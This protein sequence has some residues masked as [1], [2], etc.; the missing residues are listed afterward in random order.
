MKNGP[1]GAIAELLDNA[2][3][4]EAGSVYVDLHENQ[5]LKKNVLTF[6]DDGFGTPPDTLRRMPSETGW[7]S[8]GGNDGN[9]IGKYG[10]GFK[11][12]SVSTRSS[13]PGAHQAEKK[14]HR[15]EHGRRRCCGDSSGG[16][17]GGGGGGGSRVCRRRSNGATPSLLRLALLL[18]VLVS[19]LCPA[20]RAIRLLGKCS[21]RA[22]N[23]TNPVVAHTLQYDPKNGLS[24]AAPQAQESWK[25]IT[26]RSPITN[27][28]QLSSQFARIGDHGT[29]IL[30]SRL[31]LF[32]DKAELA[33]TAE[34]KGIQSVYNDIQLM[35]R[36]KE[37]VER[38]AWA[39]E[40][41]RMDWSMRAYVA[42]LYRK[43]RVHMYV[44][45]KIVPTFN[46]EASMRRVKGANAYLDRRSQYKLYL[47]YSEQCAQDKLKG[48]MM[49]NANRLIASDE[50]NDALAMGY[51][52]IMDTSAVPDIEVLNNKQRYVSSSQAYHHLSAWIRLTCSEFEEYRVALMGRTG[53]RDSEV[54]PIHLLPSLAHLSRVGARC[55]GTQRCAQSARGLALRAKLL[56]SLE[57]ALHSPRGHVGGSR[58]CDGH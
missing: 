20:T 24:L 31:R 51:L 34:V 2:S 28:Q 15:S 5:D 38:R 45:D 50:F 48:I 22:P 39:S 41:I 26:E 47:G 36:R 17:G 58:R 52:G 57:S 3:G 19:W 16:D 4:A 18:G 46:I 23:G 56:G 6:R 44:Q 53:G 35:M 40:R 42:V 29:L 25:E 12:R 10:Q 7:S 37:P 43:P 14:S 11:K 33:A 54:D 8:K 9:Q 1:L 32:G 21:R 27:I 13:G 49:Y 30:I 55:T